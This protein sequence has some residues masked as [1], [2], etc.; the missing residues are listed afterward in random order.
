MGRGNGSKEVIV[1]AHVGFQ[2]IFHCHMALSR[3]LDWSSP[4]THLGCH[5]AIERP[6][7]WRSPVIPPPP[8]W[9]L[10][11][12]ENYII[13]LN[14]AFGTT[15]ILNQCILKCFRKFQC[16]HYLT[17]DVQLMLL[18]ISF[19]TIVKLGFDSSWDKI[20]ISNT[21]IHVCYYK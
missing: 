18:E 20:C 15:R 16:V 4:V 3:Y 14:D 9:N 19:V 7:H 8:Y 13:I 17:Q 6:R 2:V 1:K 5:K 12:V 21:H 11:H 10:L